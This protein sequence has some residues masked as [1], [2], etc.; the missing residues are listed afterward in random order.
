M[1]GALKLG[2]RWLYLVHR[3]IGVG[4]CLLFA[5]WFVSGLVMMYVPYPRLTDRERLGGL[6]AIDWGQVKLR[7][8][9]AVEAA[10]S[11]GWPQRLKLEMMAGEPVYR[12]ADFRRETL[13][14]RD[15]RRIEAVDRTQALAIARG[16]SRLSA[17]A[18]VGAVERDQWTVGEGFDAHRPLYK[19]AFADPDR[20]VLYVSSNTGEVVLDTRRVERLWNWVGTVPHWIYFTR[21]RSNG[22]AW[23]QVILWTSGLGMVGAVSGL[24]IGLLRLHTRRRYRDERVSP[25]RGW[26]KW[27]HVGGLVTGLTLATW[28]FSGWL[29]MGP[30]G[31]FEGSALDFT[32]R[33]RYA[34]AG[35]AFPFDPS[36]A[37]FPA[38]AKEARFVWVAGRPEVVLSDAALHRTVIDG[39]TG[40]PLRVGEAAL[41]DNARTLLPQAHLARRQRLV[42]EDVYWYAHHAEPRLPMLRA[43]FDDRAGTWFHI[44]PLTGELAGM[45]TANDRLGRWAFNF[46]HDFDLPL[47]LNSRPSWDILMWVLLLGGLT[48]SVS[49]VVIAWRRLKRKGAEIRAWARRLGRK[50]APVVLPGAE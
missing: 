18:A 42:A 32:A 30:N 19:V 7:P 33:A 27:H 38:G 13:S 36:A 20:T 5:M 34:A 24:W 37:R 31:W 29:S 17:P 49:G 25:Y 8:D 21:L 2:R 22:P 40:Q 15:G 35:A 46:L 47:L 43:V 11:T 1:Q 45:M 4:A 16:F 6:D 39:R 10:G 41:F 3:W 14:A 28:V 23:T 48:I 44:D 26:M 12:V 50:R 9:Q